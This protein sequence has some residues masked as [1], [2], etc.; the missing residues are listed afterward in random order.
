MRWPTLS[1][2]ERE[3][4]VEMALRE[5]RARSSAASGDRSAG[6]RASSASPS[7]SAKFSIQATD[8]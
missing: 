8:L 1:R 5:V 4:E 7:R 6:A 2:I 3:D